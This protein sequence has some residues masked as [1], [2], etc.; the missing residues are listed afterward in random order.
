MQGIVKFWLVGENASISSVGA[1]ETGHAVERLLIDLNTS[2]DYEF[3]RTLAWND[4]TE[5]KLIVRQAVK[6]IK[7]TAY[8]KGKKKVDLI[9]SISGYANKSEQEV[10]AESFADVY[11]N[12]N[13][14]NPLSIEIKRIVLETYKKYKGD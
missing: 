2:Y 4:G 8:G 14:A 6:N 1:H 10:L 13:Y 5:A 12:G 9:K 7:Q 3:Q 11:A